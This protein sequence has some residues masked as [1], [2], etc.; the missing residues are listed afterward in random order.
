MQPGDND[1]GDDVDYT[2]SMFTMHIIRTS[3]ETEKTFG[4]YC[5]NMQ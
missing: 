2:K 5:F 3:L 1:Y 4:W